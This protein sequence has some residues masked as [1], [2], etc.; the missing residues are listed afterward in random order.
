MG[1]STSTHAHTCIKPIPVLVGKV[2]H[3]GTKTHMGWHCGFASTLLL[4][5]H[6]VSSCSQQWLGVLCGGGSQLQTF[7]LLI[8][9]V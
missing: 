5:L 7:Y 6:P 1:H 9:C 2:S 4:H 8:Y 3:V